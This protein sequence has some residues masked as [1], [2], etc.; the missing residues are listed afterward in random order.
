LPGTREANLLESCSPARRHLVRLRE[1]NCAN[2]RRGASTRTR[3]AKPSR[4]SAP[5]KTVRTPMPGPIPVKARLPEGEVT[6]LALG[7][8]VPPPA[9]ALVVVVAAVGVVVGDPPPATA[10]TGAMG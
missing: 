4:I 1:A 2:A 9:G 10:I 7:A 6:G 3:R 8:V 5:P